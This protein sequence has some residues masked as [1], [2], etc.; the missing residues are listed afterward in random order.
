MANKTVA[1]SVSEK[2]AAKAE[3]LLR[4]VMRLEMGVAHGLLGAFLG[5]TV[6]GFLRH[7]HLKLAQ[8]QLVHWHHKTCPSPI[9]IP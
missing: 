4:V 9:P 5:V 3:W 1:Y 8:L 6:Q 7:G 2:A